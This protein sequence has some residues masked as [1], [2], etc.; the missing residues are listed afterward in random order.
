[1]QVSDRDA[2][3]WHGT[4]HFLCVFHISKN[5]AKKLK[6][7]FARSEHWHKVNSLFWKIA[8]QSYSQSV[9]TWAEDWAALVAMVESHAR[10]S[11]RSVLDQNGEK[12]DKRA[13]ALEWL[14]SL[15]EQRTQWAARYVFATC[16]FGIHLTQRS[17]SINAVLK[18]TVRGRMLLTEVVKEVESLNCTSRDRHAAKAHLVSL[19]NSSGKRQ[20]SAHQRWCSRWRAF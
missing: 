11:D 20:T 14:R 10:G 16:T 3:P 18:K 15:E 1:V 6:P 17:E 8:K 12:K 4:L 13:L 9:D 19:K 2:D 7:L 5:F